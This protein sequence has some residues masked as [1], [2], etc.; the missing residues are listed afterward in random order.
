M[1]LIEFPTPR[2]MN[3]PGP[4]QTNTEDILSLEPAI[5]TAHVDYARGQTI[6][7]EPTELAKL[8]E[9]AA[10]TAIAK[11]RQC[12]LEGDFW[13]ASIYADLAA[14]RFQYLSII[15]ARQHGAVGPPLPGATVTI[16][17][18]HYSAPSSVP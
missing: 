6:R 14:G 4:L 17:H 2:E 12:R 8:V 9:D 3:G 1:Q 10:M 16:K 5:E 18:R 15:L 11:M 13:R 7:L